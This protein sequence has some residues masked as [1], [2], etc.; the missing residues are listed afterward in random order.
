MNWA[1]DSVHINDELKI[2]C[3]L[4][5]TL[6]LVLNGKYIFTQGAVSSLGFTNNFEMTKD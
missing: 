6:N 2:V 1:G 5:T 3:S 4:H